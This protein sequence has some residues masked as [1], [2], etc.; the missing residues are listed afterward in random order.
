MYAVAAPKPLAAQDEHC[1]FDT[2]RARAIA[3]QIVGTF[4]GTFTFLATVNGTTYIAAGLK[5]V[6]GGAVAS[7]TT[8]AGIWVLEFNP[9][10]AK[11]QVFWTARTSGAVTVTAIAPE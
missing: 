10:Y 7:T 6:A 3:I 8:T 2:L 1:E 11:V 4:V 5:P 9:G